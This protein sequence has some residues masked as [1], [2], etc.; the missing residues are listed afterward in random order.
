MEL[1]WINLNFYHTC[2]CAVFEIVVFNDGCN[3]RI[4]FTDKYLQHLLNIP[5]MHYT[6]W[7]QHSHELCVLFHSFPS[8]L[9]RQFSH[10]GVLYVFDWKPTKMETEYSP[11]IPIKELYIL[12]CYCFCFSF[13]IIWNS[14]YFLNTFEKKIVLFKAKQGC[15]ISPG[16]TSTTLH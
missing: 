4:F 12:K 1:N 9:L 15:E 6:Q 5:E 8:V 13:R 11:L 7:K 16:W 2:L 14:H 10:G 3:R